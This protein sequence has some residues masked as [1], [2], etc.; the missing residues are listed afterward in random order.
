[1]RDGTCEQILYKNK[2]AP[3]PAAPSSSLRPPLQ[4]LKMAF[5][6]A[7]PPLLLSAAVSPARNTI[8]RAY[9]VPTLSRYL[10]FINVMTYDFHG[11]WERETGHVSPL[12]FR[13]GDR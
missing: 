1:M 2:T 9:D 8:D 11:A 4:E 5:A 10:D 6:R 12:T 3:H 7:S 13:D